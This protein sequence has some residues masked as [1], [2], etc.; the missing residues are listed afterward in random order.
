MILPYF[1]NIFKIVNFDMFID[2]KSIFTYIIIIDI[3]ATYSFFLL[4]C[5]ALQTTQ[6]YDRILEIS[7]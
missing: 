2:L 6:I 1:M 3:I 5:T 4:L 7:E